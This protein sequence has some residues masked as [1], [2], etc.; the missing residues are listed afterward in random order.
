MPFFSIH[1][2]WT[3]IAWRGIGI[4][5]IAW[6]ILAVFSSKDEDT[7]ASL[8]WTL[9]GLAWAGHLWKL[10]VGVVLLRGW[11]PPIGW[12]AATLTFLEMAITYMTFAIIDHAGVFWIGPFALPIWL[13][14]VLS[15]LGLLV[16]SL[17]P[18]PQSD[19]NK[20]LRYVLPEGFRNKWLG[21]S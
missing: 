14:L 11:I 19:L 7:S 1:K 5:L 13:G 2:S 17:F 15:L 16:A 12:I 6:A 21:P 4:Y 8:S 3:A 9:I 20:E 10:L 18:P